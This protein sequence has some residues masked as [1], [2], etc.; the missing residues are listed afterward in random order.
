MLL[1]AYKFQIRRPLISRG[2]HDA[3]VH[4]G[5]AGGRALGEQLSDGKDKESRAYS[6]RIENE[7][8]IS[9]CCSLLPKN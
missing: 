9:H 3:A 5:I 8:S 2:T 7:I 4:H 1:D 6:H